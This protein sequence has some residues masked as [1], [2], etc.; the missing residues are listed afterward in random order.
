M[1]YYS[2]SQEWKWLFHNAVDWD[3]I[4]PLYYPKF[5]TADGFNSKEEVLQFIE[6]MLTATGE[7]TAGAVAERA[8]RLDEEG[9]GSIENGATIP[10]AA[11]TEFYNE[12]KEL[13]IIGLSASPE[14]GG[15]GA[16]HIASLMTF[17]Q[18]NK[19]CISSATQMGF[20][21]SM[22]DMVERFCE[23]EDK[24]RLIPKIIAGEISGSMCLTEP[25]AG[26]DV[27]AVATT[28]TKQEDGTFL[29]NGTKMFITNGG[30]GFGF[31]LARLKDAP[32]GLAG[33]SLFLCEQYL[34]EEKKQ[35]YIVSKNEHKMGLHGSFTCEIVYE[36]S[37]AKLVGKPNQGFRYMLHLMNEARIAVGL[38]TLGGM[39]ACLEYARKYAE[40]RAQ[41]GKKLMDLP[42][43]ARNMEDWETE[44]DAFRALM[45]DTISYFDQYQ[46][47]DLCKR[48]GKELNKEQED[49]L[50]TAVKWIRRRTP[51]VKGY[52]AESFTLL[53]QRAIQALGG[54]GF[55]EEYD[56]SRFHRDSF[57]TLLYEGTTQIQALMAMKDLMKFVMR[58]PAKYFTALVNANPLANFFGASSEYESKFNGAQY[59][60]KK[61]FMLLLIRTLKPETDTQNPGELKKFFD[62]KEWLKEENIEKLMKHAETIAQG[63]AYIETLRVLM[64]H[65]NKHDSRGDLFDRYFR[66]VTPRFAHI[67]SDW[68]V[69]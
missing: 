53:S 59:E 21:T 1:N 58:S 19:A 65:A 22:I 32:E 52:G 44:R 36:N 10:G 7:W 63:L 47:L 45:V 66:L 6:D 5:P 20:F 23:Q 40:E 42:L 28:A 8:K 35:N 62:A 46:K 51:L 3:K 15:M 4:I 13:E 57:A 69:R 60:F 54:Y 34:G 56:T 41:F 64:L 27:G 61:N 50:K 16:P 37:V 18:L 29:L 24:E 9:A 43:Y 68:S 33:I 48:H 49:Q 26:S 39:E 30:G 25:G 11:L 31:A 67:Y 38:Q 2:D 14:F 12:A 55:I 17:T